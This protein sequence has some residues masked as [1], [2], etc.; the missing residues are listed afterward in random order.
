MK[1]GKLEDI[2]NVDFSLPPEPEQNKDVFS[3]LSFA[4]ILQI[5]YVAFK[6]R[7]RQ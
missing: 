2:S 3:S 6:Y 1:F 4:Q 7:G 5:S